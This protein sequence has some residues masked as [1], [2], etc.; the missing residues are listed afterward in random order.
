MVAGMIFAVLVT[1]GCGGGEEAARTVEVTTEVT[2]EVIAEV[3]ET[4]TVGEPGAAERTLPGDEPEDVEAPP[5][6]PGR[7]PGPAVPAEVDQTAEIGE[8]A[9]LDTGETVT[10]T[11]ED[12]EVSS[13]DAL[14]EPRE[15]AEFYVVEAEVCVP[16]AATE[17]LTVDARAFSL[18]AS[19]DGFRIA[20]PPA[21]EPA[22]DNVPIDP[23]ECNIGSVT[24]QVEEDEEPEVVTFDGPQNAEWRLED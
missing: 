15:G 18:Q 16:A 7:L 11:A 21:R 5:G 1:A 12:P 14:Y 24:F 22:F 19:E 4:V 23:G 8:T 10:V 9:E 6:A 17:S 2:T 20:R 3:T 13:D